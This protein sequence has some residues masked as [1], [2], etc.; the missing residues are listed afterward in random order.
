MKT[1]LALSLLI[2]SSS[3][4]GQPLD[5]GQSAPSERVTYT[6][7]NL[8]SAA[9][10]SALERRIRLAAGRVC[11][12]GGMQEGEALGANFRC[13]R[14]AVS[15]GLRQMNQVVAGVRSSG[16]TLAASALVI[17]AH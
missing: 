8:A 2:A 11:D 7:L 12:F 10:Q 1:M 9:G 3:A 16:D 17:S 4:I 6:D 13:Y 15:D 5:S 14:T